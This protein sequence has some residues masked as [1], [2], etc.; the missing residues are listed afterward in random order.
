M[1]NEATISVG[2]QIALS[3]PGEACLRCMEIITEE[4]LGRDKE[5]Y[6][7]SGAPDQQVVSMNGVLASE[8]VNVFLKLITG[9]APAFAPP[10]YLVYNG[11]KH[12]LSA[13]PFLGVGAAACPH[14]PVTNAGDRIGIG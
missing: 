13:H 9:Y 14:Y 10:R 7:E 6:V 3:F 8:A 12:E 11:L 5:E 2:G 1:K 4:S